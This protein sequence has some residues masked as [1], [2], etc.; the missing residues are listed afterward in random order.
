MPKKTARRRSPAHPEEVIP[1]YPIRSWI[2][3]RTGRPFHTVTLRLENGQY[4]SALD[5]APSIRATAKTKEKAELAAIRLYE[6][7]DTD[8]DKRDHALLSDAL[9]R[10]RTPWAE[11]KEKLHAMRDDVGSRAERSR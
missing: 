6:Q 9:K 2:D 1:D 10:P 4:L 3:E 5:F 11:V 8:D 7:Q